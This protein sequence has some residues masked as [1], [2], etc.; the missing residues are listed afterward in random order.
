VARICGYVAS[1]ESRLDLGRILSES[2]SL[3]RPDGAAP[4]IHQDGCIGIATARDGQLAS[5]ADGRYVCAVDGSIF[6]SPRLEEYLRPRRPDFESLSPPQILLEL[7]QSRGV[8]SFQL[9]EGGFVFAIVDTQDETLVLGRDIFGVKSLFYARTPSGIVFSS[10]LAGIASSPW[11]DRE[12]GLAGMLEYLACGYVSAPW[13][14]YQDASALKAG[15][16]VIITDGRVTTHQFHNLEPRSWEF[17]DTEGRSEDQLVDRLDELA[18]AAVSRRL[19]A[20]GEVAAYLSGGLDT[21]LLCALLKE[22]GGRKVLAYTLGFNGRSH[23]ET[24]NARAVAAQL[25]IEH[26]AFNLEK[27]E[28]FHALSM[29][30]VIYGQ[31]LADISAVPTTVIAGKVGQQFDA[32]FDGQGPDFLFGNFD[33]RALYYSYHGVPRAFREGMSRVSRFLT[34]KLLR[35][36]T[37][38][39]L[40]VAELLR[41]PD[42]FWI[43]T[44][45]FKSRD[46]EQLVGE[47]VYAESF[48]CHRFLNS[49]RDIPLA[50][51]LRLAQFLCYGISDVQFK[52]SAAHQASQVDI[53]CPYLDLDLFNFVQFLPTRFKY[54]RGYGKYLQKKLLYRKVPKR[55]LERPKRGFIMDFV[56]FGVD[57]TRA[58]TDRYLT[59]K[60]LGETGLFN[61]DFAL[62]CV[63]DYYHGDTNM[64]PKLWTLLMFEIWREKLSVTGVAGMN[65]SRPEPVPVGELA[66]V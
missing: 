44:R 57:A 38:P 51:R 49:R 2:Y 58:L 16:C 54:R 26:R 15:E 11:F 28:A 27:E 4:L 10:S 50:E 3:K 37:S 12:I 17:L 48:W 36:W 52:A 55:F 8:E 1:G 14:I 42:F 22:N 32:I 62:K 56:E 61:V 13:T 9:L 21:S 63:A 34:G 59:R 5:S 18:A 6:N 41:Q 35:K 30:P 29:L 65:A 39:N 24:A 45:M 25:G 60:R 47:P 43:F 46:L 64:G 20:T 7:Y 19:P 53:L 23:D 31:P 33:L 40:D 66:N